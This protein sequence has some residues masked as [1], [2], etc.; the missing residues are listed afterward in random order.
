MKKPTQKEKI[1]MY[2]DVLHELYLQ[3]TCMNNKRI[4]ELLSNIHTWSHAHSNGEG[5]E[6][7]RE[8]WITNAFW[9]LKN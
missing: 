4:L 5:T 8:K 7:E 1:R 6:F 3:Q 9:K 2:E